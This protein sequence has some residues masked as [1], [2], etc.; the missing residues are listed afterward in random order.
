MS[1]VIE[2]AKKHFLEG[3]TH[4]E[5]KRLEEADRAFSAAHRLVPD[6]PS[7][8]TNLGAVRLQLGRPDEAVPLLGRATKLEPDNLQAWAHLGIAQAE[9]GD[10]DQAVASFDHAL[11]IDGK[12][13]VLWTHRGTALR[14]M[15][16]LPEA[17]KSFEQAREHGADPHVIGYF[18]ASM[19]GGEAPPMPPR[20]YVENLFDRYADDFS[21]HLVEV[22]GYRAPEELVDGLAPLGARW[23]DDVLD[24]GCG[25]GL[26]GPLVKG[27]A[28]RIDGV[29][30]SARMLAQAR[31]LGTY[32][33]L[34]HA[35][36]VEWL[37][38]STQ[39]YDLV[40]AADVFIYVGAL[41][42]VFADVA[43]LLRPGG[44]FAFTV[45]ENTRTDGVNPQ[46]LQLMPSLRY[47][48]PEAY[49]RRV[50]AAAGLQ[51]RAMHR[52]PLRQ[53][54]AQPVPG[55]YYYLAKP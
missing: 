10:L 12:S 14:E 54:Q 49:V 48:H 29:D 37:K 3:V 8:L 38:I 44:M 53:D 47:A 51:V 32:D 35:D 28:S 30:L 52:A 18:L 36:I 21:D 50:A 15:G 6:R 22:L 24:L 33:D 16:R 31:E 42:S 27:M 9:T 43:R 7:V 1:D 11:R 4:F 13:A 45:E 25:T 19:Q 40:L 41:E 2:T 17:V 23:F 5:A 26:C 46:E 20:A 39:P 55:A 34:V